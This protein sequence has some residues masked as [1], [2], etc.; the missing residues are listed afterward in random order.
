MEYVESMSGARSQPTNVGIS[1]KCMDS[2]QCPKILVIYR[3]ASMFHYG[4][5]KIKQLH[6]HMSTNTCK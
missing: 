5:S 1:K 6:Q 2:V 4:L 3:W